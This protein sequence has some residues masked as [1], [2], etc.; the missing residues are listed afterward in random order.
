MMIVCLKPEL[1]ERRSMQIRTV[2][3]FFSMA[4]QKACS[5]FISSRQLITNKFGINGTSDE[6]E[7]YMATNK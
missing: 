2:F 6:Y 4:R 7:R 3:F 1:S 5:T